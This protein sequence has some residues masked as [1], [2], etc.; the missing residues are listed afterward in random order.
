MKGKPWTPERRA[1][2]T[3]ETREKLRVAALGREPWNKGICQA[4]GLPKR[5]K[6]ANQAAKAGRTAA[7][8]R[9]TT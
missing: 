9:L 3:E 2:F 6:P 4:T 8:P 1:A 7:R 5:P